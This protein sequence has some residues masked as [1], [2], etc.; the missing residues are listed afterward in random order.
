MRR[1]TRRRRSYPSVM[2]TG[3]TRWTRFIQL[4]CLVAGAVLLGWAA[5]LAVQSYGIQRDGREVTGTVVDVRRYATQTSGGTERAFT[6]DVTFEYDLDG[7]TR[8][9]VWENDDRVWKIGRQQP[10][11]VAPAT[12]TSPRLAGVWGLYRMSFA[13]AGIA[14]VLAACAP[15]I[16][17]VMRR[18]PVRGTPQSRRSQTRR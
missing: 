10:L 14:T 6:N 7:R 11:L 5:V 2:M 1:Q 9:G 4:A 16:G 18:A 3:G 15:L 17:W 8:R 13:Y 12:P